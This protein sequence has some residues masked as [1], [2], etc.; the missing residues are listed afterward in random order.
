MNRSAEALLY[1][2]SRFS[3]VYV[4]LKETVFFPGELSEPVRASSSIVTRN[5]GRV[6]SR[7][8]AGT[9]KLSRVAVKSTWPPNLILNGYH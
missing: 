2:H 8:L 5:L 3:G 4:M 9:G 1:V 7:R 6:A